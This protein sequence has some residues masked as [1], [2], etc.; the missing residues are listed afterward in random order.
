MRH[1]LCPMCRQ[2]GRVLPASSPDAVA[3]YYRCD[4]CG[5][6]WTHR[7]DAPNS[8]PTPVTVPPKDQ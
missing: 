3:T 1:L 4:I 7:N 5:R 8:P 2:P 6:V